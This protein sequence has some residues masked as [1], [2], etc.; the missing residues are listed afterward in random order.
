MLDTLFPCK[1]TYAT[2][3]YWE[4][5]TYMYFNMKTKPKLEYSQEILNLWRVDNWVQRSF[6]GC[7]I[8]RFNE[9]FICAM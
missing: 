9:N 3:Y 5:Q 7:N 4:L 1:V 6:E 8:D 2:Y